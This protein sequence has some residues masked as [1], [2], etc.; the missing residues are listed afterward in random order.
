MPRTLLGFLV[1]ALSQ[2]AAS[3]DLYQQC[4]DQRADAYLRVTRM[5]AYTVQPPYRAG[6]VRYLNISDEEVREVQAAASEVVGNVLVTIAEVREKCPCEDG[7]DCTDQVWVLAYL[8]SG[9]VGL[10]LSKI[11][12]HWTIG[13]VQRWWL[14]HDNLENN[15][16]KRDYLGFKEAEVELIKNFPTCGLYKGDLEK[17]ERTYDKCVLAAEKATREHP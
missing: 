6:P 2:T 11:G 13:T 14:Q 7:D 16:F 17:I 10:S 8:P 1:L 3:A 12:G 9:T 5:R 4:A 15:K